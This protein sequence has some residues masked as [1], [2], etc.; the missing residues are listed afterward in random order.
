VREAQRERGFRRPSGCW[1]ATTLASHRPYLSS[2]RSE[3]VET[4]YARAENR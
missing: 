4:G 3:G 2:S 1:A